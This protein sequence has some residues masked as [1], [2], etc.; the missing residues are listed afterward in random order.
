MLLDMVGT[1][2]VVP[3]MTVCNALGSYFVSL[4]PS[5]MFFIS[6]GYECGMDA[7]CSGHFSS[8]VMFDLCSRA[9]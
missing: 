8:A 3:F 9:A 5:P 6:F 2:C 1:D 7:P 4:T